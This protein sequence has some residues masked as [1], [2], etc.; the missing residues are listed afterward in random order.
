MWGHTHGLDHV[1]FVNKHIRADG[2]AAVSSTSISLSHEIKNVGHFDFYTTDVVWFFF[3]SVLLSVRGRYTI[4]L[5]S[6]YSSIIHL[7]AKDFGWSKLPYFLFACGVL[8][9]HPQ[10][11]HKKMKSLY[12]F[13][14]RD[15]D[16]FVFPLRWILLAHVC[17]HLRPIF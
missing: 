4:F 7:N 1:V 17:R 13:S 11:K 9:F 3:C 6:F 15:F 12:L 2:M 16:L 8:C 5:F 10:G 14:R